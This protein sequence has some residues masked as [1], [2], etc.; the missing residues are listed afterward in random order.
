MFLL[1]V[2]GELDQAQRAAVEHFVTLHPDLEEELQLLQQAVIDIDT[3]IE[4][5]NKQNLFKS[6][7]WDEAHL[8]PQQEQMLLH[9][10][11]E[12]DGT[13][14]AS[15]VAGIENNPLLQ[16]EW[17]TLTKAKLERETIVMP[18]K[19]DLYKHEQRKVRPIGTA[20]RWMAAAAAVLG[21]GIFTLYNNY[22]ND[23]A[24][25]G[26][27]TN[28]QQ[29]QKNT[30]TPEI[31]TPKNSPVSNNPTTPSTPSTSNTLPAQTPATTTH[32][33]HTSTSPALAQHRNTA[34]N[35]HTA[36]TGTQTTHTIPSTSTPEASTA[37]NAN[38]MTAQNQPDMNRSAGI[39]ETAGAVNII[40]QP[41][42]LASQQSLRNA[43]SKQSNAIPAM[44][45][46]HNPSAEMQAGD[47]AGD[48]D[49]VLIAGARV[50]K[51][52]VR[53]ILRTVTRTIGRKFQS[54]VSDVAYTK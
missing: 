4:M 44:F 29:P 51:E 21:L 1:Y 16:H 53:G 13:Q 15:L 34:N 18:G 50:K 48:D 43:G 7:R 39:Q 37:A 31:V 11:G 24:G 8:T 26:L 19:A 17:N 32:F 27:A 49:V 10:D 42:I 35:P 23:G 38:S 20:W 41:A 2:D 52:K 47:D 46:S 6:T 22:S 33:N 25:T 14:S 28:T 12:L 30:S 5:P 54:N 36:T 40:D 3:H 45:A 9:M